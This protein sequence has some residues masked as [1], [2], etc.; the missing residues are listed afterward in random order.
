M[1]EA[2]HQLGAKSPRDVKSL[3]RCGMGMC[4]GRICGRSISDLFDGG[5]VERI[6]TA[7]RP[8]ITPITL[9]ELAQ[10]GLL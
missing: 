6:Q 1:N 8:I 10:E 2:R 3:T 5:E 9:G 7:S 4:Q